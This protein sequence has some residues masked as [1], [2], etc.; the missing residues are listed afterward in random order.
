MITY[1][2]LRYIGKEKEEALKMLNDLR[3]VTALNLKDKL[4]QWGDQFYTKKPL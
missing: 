1:G 3:V 2:L 4:L